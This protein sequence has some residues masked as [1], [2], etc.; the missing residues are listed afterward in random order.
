MKYNK[1]YFREMWM[2]FQNIYYSQKEMWFKNGD[3][4]IRKIS[5]YGKFFNWK[6]IKSFLNTLKF[7]KVTTMFYN[8]I[9]T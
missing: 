8:A 2:V 1:N 4:K 6:S 9:K 7:I 3:K 5:K